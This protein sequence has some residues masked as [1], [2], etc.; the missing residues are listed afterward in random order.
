MCLDYV[1]IWNVLDQGAERAKKNWARKYLYGVSKKM[2][3][4]LLCY[5]CRLLF[6][7]HAR[8]LG[9]H[10][11]CFRYALSAPECAHI[12]ALFQFVMSANFFET[13]TNESS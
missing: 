4:V 10:F 3:Y 6:R 2:S 11:S 7:L 9:A 8:M 12:F 1:V 5:V 13:G